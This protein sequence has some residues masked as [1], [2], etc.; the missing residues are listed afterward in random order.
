VSRHDDSLDDRQLAELYRQRFEGLGDYRLDV[1][2]RLVRG[3]FEPRFM[4]SSESVLDL[5]AGHGEFILHS[6]AANRMAMDLNPDMVEILNGTGIVTFQQECTK[7]W[8]VPDESLDVVFSSNLL[9]H[10]PSKEAVQETVRNAFE[11]IKPGGRIILLGPNVR[12]VPGSYWDFWDHHVPLT[13][14]SIDELLTTTGFKVTT[15]IPRFLPYTM[16]ERR[17][18]PAWTVSLYLKMPIIWRVLGKQFLV[19]GE[20]PERGPSQSMSIS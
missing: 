7:S 19:V 20:K 11:A 18:P 17:P 9:E 5:G 1:W 13:D 3:Y 8:P 15:R 12:Y 6:R 4:S 16:S 2:G 14:R 10:L